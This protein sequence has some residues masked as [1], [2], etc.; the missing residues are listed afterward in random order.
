MSFDRLRTHEESALPEPSFWRLLYQYLWPFLYFRDVTRGQ[1]MERQQNYRHNRS[2]RILLP[3]FAFKWAVLTALCFAL[4]VLPAPVVLTACFY[5]TGTW[6]LVG[7]N[8]DGIPE[9][10]DYNFGTATFQG[11]TLRLSQDGEWEM[12][13]S[14]DHMEQNE[15]RQ[16][17]DY[18]QYGRD[19][20]DLSFASE[21]YGDHIEGGVDDGY[22]YMIYDFDGDGVYETEFTFER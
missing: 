15:S 13:I 12:T 22:V 19:D 18:G 4:G 7:I 10:E 2:Q 8:E 3:G 5:V 16:L 17:E 6:T 20:E 1:K 9:S 11:G 21:A 14:Y